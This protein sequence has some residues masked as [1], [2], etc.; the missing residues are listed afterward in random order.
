M[1]SGFVDKGADLGSDKV[2]LIK[3]PKVVVI[4]GESISSLA[5][6]EI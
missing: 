1:A 2:R 4:G 6:G 5:F 3:K